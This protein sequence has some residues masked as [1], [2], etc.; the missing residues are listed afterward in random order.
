MCSAKKAGNLE[1][2]FGGDFLYVTP[3]VKWAGVQNTGQK[4]FYTPD[5][6]VRDCSNSVLV[7]GSAITK[8]EDKQKAGYEIL[9][10][11]SK[12]L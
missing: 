9:Q 1:K 11:I 5:K 2:E 6:A 8:A 12:Y 3:G 7:V 10:A 4:Q